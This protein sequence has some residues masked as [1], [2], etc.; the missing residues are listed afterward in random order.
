MSIPKE[1][2]QLMI[3]LMYLVLTAMLALNVSA[4]IINAFF[5]L[6]S[7]IKQ[8][9]EMVAA[10]HVGILKGIKTSVDAKPQYAQYMDIANK[11]KSISDEFTKYMDGVTKELV[12][13]AGGVDD[14]HH[15]GRPKKY[16][17]KDVTTRLF[18]LEGQGRGAEV[19]KRITETR[20]KLLA[21]IPSADKAD[22]EKKLPLIV[23]QV[24]EDAKG[25]SWVD[26]KFKQMPVAAV[27]PGLSKISADA[28]TSETAILNYC[29]DRASGKTEITFDGFKVA[30]APKK[31][32]LTRG[33]KFEAEVYM[34]A[35]SKSNASGVT[36]NVN[37]SGLPVKEGVAVYTTGPQ[38]EL[39][40]KTVSATA[41]IKNPM[42]GAT[43]TVKGEL[44]YEVGEKSVTVSA[45]KMNV[46][47]IGVDNPVAVSAAGISSLKLKV[48]MSGG[49]ISRNSDGTYTVK[50]SRPGKATIDVSGEGLTARK[51]FRVLPIP[52]PAPIVN[53]GSA[54]Q[55]KGGAIPA[56]QAQAISGVIAELSG[57][58]FDAKCSIQS[59]V[60]L[61][62]PRRDDLQQANV[63]GPFNAEAGRLLAQ[64]KPGDSYQFQTIKA[65]CPGDV[66]ARPIGSMSFIIR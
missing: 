23:D 22:M 28:V 18:T 43:Q 15:D 2:R 44:K 9:S 60:L 57:F 5:A 10:T 35:F 14:K 47:Y 32:Y 33:D 19:E 4:E 24:P 20:A 53:V 61:R 39:G 30:I 59:F 21:L 7:G 51:E 36:I 16:K 27:M 55:R 45:E 64:A 3:N 48:S 34:A 40:E 58:A 25:K 54:D 38:N 49:D 17:D 52:D 63:S 42:T 62:I 11:A 26:L 56:A 41:T 8:S 66:A 12:E 65:R 31:A 29:L 46:F 50:V 13:A 37:G 1:P 6:N